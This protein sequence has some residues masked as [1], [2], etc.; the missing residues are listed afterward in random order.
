MP[1]LC[2]NENIFLALL[3]QLYRVSSHLLQQM[4]KRRLVCD[5]QWFCHDHAECKDLMCACRASC[6][7]CGSTR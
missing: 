4:C 5:C 6:M 7:Q 3:M 1:C 2:S